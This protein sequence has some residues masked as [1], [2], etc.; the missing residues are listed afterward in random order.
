M[1]ELNRQNIPTQPTLTPKIIEFGTGNFIRAF[2]NSMIQKLYEESDFAGSVVMVI[3]TSSQY[4]AYN[5]VTRGIENGEVVNESKLITCVE[6][7]VHPWL[8]FEKY[9]ELAESETLEI[10]LTN[11]TEAGVVFDAD[12]QFSDAPAASS[13][14][15][16]TQLLY[17][18]FQH[19]DGDVSKGWIFI[20]CELLQDNG[21]K[22]RDC[23]HWNLGYD[24]K[25]WIFNCNTFCDTLVDR[26]VPGF[27]QESAAKI[28]E[29]LGF[30]DQLLVA[31]E[32]FHIWAIEAP[33]IVQQLLPFDK[34]GLNVRYTDS[35]EKYRTLKVR[36]LNGAHTSMVPV[37][38]LAGKETV[39]ETLE[40]A[41]TS[42]FVQDVIFKEILPTL[43]FPQE[44]LERYANDI[45]D[46]FKNPFIR[47]KLLDISLNSISKFKTRVLSSLLPICEK[48]NTIP[49]NMA[50]S[51]AA[52]IYYYKGEKNP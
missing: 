35:L 37:G 16:M 25:Y 43:D 30:N 34:I 40:T 3:P 51:I 9:L 20:P 29:K 14:G 2:A 21:Q 6:Q 41:P 5:V 49:G 48:F 28:Q 10:I 46:R 22:L 39:R 15:K 19:F 44:E 13:P 45:L 32:P 38:V 33:E 42:E 27:P 31:A 36:I 1:Q 50:K 4:A 12:D 17:K 18:R 52:I 23:D 7:V 8:E 11:V 47:H 24:F 26:I